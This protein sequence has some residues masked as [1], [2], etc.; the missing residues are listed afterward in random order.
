MSI[1]TFGSNLS[2]RPDSR[3]D[4]ILEQSRQLDDVRAIVLLKRAEADYPDDER[5]SFR[6]G[7]LYHKMNRRPEAEEAYLKTIRLDSCHAQALN[8][9]GNIKLDAGET[10]A[11]TDYYQRA[12]RC[13]SEFHS[14][15]YNLGNIFRKKSEYQ[16]A[17]SHYERALEINPDHFRTHHNLALIYLQ[18]VLKQE[19]DTAVRRAAAYQTA[20]KHF[21]ESTRLQPDDPLGH[22]NL[23]VLYERGM[24]KAKALEEYRQTR[25][26]LRT[27]SA[28]RMRVNK[29]IQ[30]LELEL[31]NQ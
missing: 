15:H 14:P 23:A 4:A 13:D 24:E 28:F 17:V 1:A 27:Q 3:A 8:N 2:A 9:L 10:E 5:I 18:I 30:N 16:Q 25:R 6:I 12:I 26:Y 7:F 11:A 31:R 22:Y 21:L 29:R 19:P 20:L